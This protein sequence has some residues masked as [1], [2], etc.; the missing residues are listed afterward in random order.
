MVFVCRGWYKFVIDSIHLT[1]G[2]RKRGD[3][4]SRARTRFLLQSFS[5]EPPRKK[6]GGRKKSKVQ[7][8]QKGLTLPSSP[9][10]G[11]DRTDDR[12]FS[13]HLYAN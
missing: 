12:C 6:V 11:F 4:V 13:E 9:S 3:D 10:L 2:F 7:V 8:E 5:F 1:I